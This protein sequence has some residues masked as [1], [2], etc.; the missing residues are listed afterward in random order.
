V[1]YIARPLIEGRFGLY[2]PIELPTIR[3]L[4]IISMVI[5]AGF[6][7]GFIPGYRAYRFS[8]GDGMIVRT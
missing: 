6:L 7:S 1:F 5:G 8:V 4:T 2:I 3:D